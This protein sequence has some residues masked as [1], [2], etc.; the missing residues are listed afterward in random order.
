MSAARK[1]K[2]PHNKSAAALS[3]S[4][5]RTCLTPSD[6]RERTGVSRETLDRL[7]VYADTLRRWQRR[8]NLVGPATVPELWHRHMLDSAQLVQHLPDGDGPVVDLGSGAG[9][10]G[11]VLAIMTPRPV[12]LI[13]SDT[14]KAAFLREAARA[15]GVS[16]RVTVHA[17][18]IAD[19]PQIAAAIITAR[20]LAALPQLL[21][22][23]EPFLGD[24]TIALFLKGKRYQEE[25]TDAKY[26]WYI[27]YETVPSATDSDAVLLRIV[28]FR[29]LEA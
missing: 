29:R 16:S 8:I 28:D 5:P 10:P 18:R 22:L 17:T 12:H 20:A 2:P 9:F 19:A 1:P 11:L 15:A 14:R 26:A 23:S 25:L 3:V 4:I 13:E 7:E 21:D 24:G 27:N 6:F